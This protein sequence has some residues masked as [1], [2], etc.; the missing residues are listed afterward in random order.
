MAQKLLIRDLTLRDG[1]QSSFATRMT[2][3]QID[4]VLPFYKDANFYAMEV[5]GGAVP[6]SVMRYLNENPWDRL[7]KIKAVVGN[8][9]KLTA[10][11]RGRNL[12]GYA[13]YTDEIIEGFCRNSIESGLG[14]MR[15]FDALNDVNNVKSTI[16]YV[17]KY[18][19]IADCA[20]CYT[21][22]PKYP[23]LGLLDKLKG[24]K[25]PEPVFTNAYFLDKAKQ[26]AALGADMVTIKDMS[27]LIQPSRIAEL[28]P[29]FKQNLSIPVDF[30]TH[31][32]PGYGL[33]AV[34]MAIIKGVDIVDTNIWNFAGGTGAPAIELV[35]IFCKKLGVELDVNMEAVA[36]INKEL[37]GIRKELEAVDASKQF[38][39]PFNPLTDQ[40]PAE[41]DKEF[42]KAIEAAKAN[43]EEALLN[44]CHAIE[45]YFNFPKPNEL[46]KKAE[47]PGGMYSNM[48]AQLKQLNSMDILEKAMELIPTVRLAAGLPPLVTP[49]SQIV[50]AQAV[51]C[52]LDIKAGKPMYSNV[53][54]QFVNLV[55]GEYGK[56]PVPVDPEFRLKIAGTREEIPY[57]TSKYQMQPNP[58][59]PE[60]G[61]V[62]LAANEKE[63]LL[64]ELFPQVAKNF[65]TKQKV[66]AY[67]AQ[68]K[69]NAPQAEKVVAEEKKNEPITGKTVKAPMP[70][71]ILRFTVKPGDTVTKGQTVVILEAM[72]M[73]N[74]IAT[75]Y[76]GT[77]KRLLVKEGTTVAADAPMIEIEA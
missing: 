64:L 37:Y 76:A 72:K 35:Y 49:T 44:A 10:L 75:D 67:E 55:K 62:K 12:F 2:Q 33:G 47:V 54:N 1:Q 20:V 58:E 4:R 56:T 71:S 29:L 13:P 16:K 17:K 15:I 70:G 31:C 77:V 57:D 61:G 21:I 34:L 74:S 65:L 7:E 5:W 69:A 6:D 50:G 38:P 45:A 52:A 42:D 23:K 32:T 28:I 51:N 27:G 9:S 8:V 63:V 14:I 39:N 40:L 25:N 3:Q 18:G 24:K 22:D 30:H 46:V 26:M 73:E 11:S 43:N 66:A 60:A 68:H 59:L 19:G 53:S 36:K 48:V 41:I